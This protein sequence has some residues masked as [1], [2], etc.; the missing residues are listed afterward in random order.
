MKLGIVLVGIAYSCVG[1]MRDWRLS[2][3]NIQATF[4]ESHPKIDVIDYAICTYRIA[5]LRMRMLKETYAASLC[6]FIDYSGSTQRNTYVESIEL[7]KNMDCDF[8]IFTR[9]DVAFK[10]RFKDFN[11]NFK[12]INIL[13]KEKNTWDD[14]NFVCDNFFGIPADKLDVFKRAIIE[15]D[16]HWLKKRFMHHILSTLSVELNDIHFCSNKHMSSKDN[17]FYKI[18]K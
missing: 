1:K 3:D 12:K 9:F 5:S 15:M 6:K 7:A 16:N 2:S 13:F 14:Y 4:N 8:Y 18:I 10:K 17:R 11:I